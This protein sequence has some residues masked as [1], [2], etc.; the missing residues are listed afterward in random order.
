MRTIRELF[1]AAAERRTPRMVV[2]SGPAGVGKSRLGWEFRKY[3][4]GLV[5]VVNW[6]HGRC[7]S[8]GE[9]VSFWAL[10][11]MMRQR[12]GI[13]EDDQPELAAIKLV[14]GMEQWVPD[15]GERA[16]VGTRLARLLGVPY[17]A[18]TGAELSRE[19]LFAGWRI[20]FERM[21]DDAAG[22]AH[23]RG[24]PARRPRPARL[25]RPPRRLVPR[26]AGLRAG[27]R[28]ARAR[29][30]PA[31]L[32]D[33]AQPGA[34]HPRPARRRVDAP[35]GR[36]PR[37]RHA[38]RGAGRDRGPGA[39]RSAVRR[40]D[41]PLA[42]RP[43]RR[44]ADRRRLPPGRRRRRARRPG[45]PARAAGRAARRPGARRA[46]AGGRRGGARHV[47][48]GR[49]A[50]RGL[51]ARGRGASA[52]GWPSCC[53]ARCS[54]SRPTRC[55][56]S[57]AATGSP[58]TCCARSPTTRCRGGTARPATSPWPRTCARRSPN[59]GEEVVDVVARHYLDA[60]AA[61]PDDPDADAL[62]EQAVAALVRAAE[63]AARTGAPDRASR[64]YSQAAE[65]LEEAGGDPRR[66]AHLFERAITA[67]Y[68]SG[69]ANEVVDLAE[70]N[71]E[72]YTALGE[73]RAAAR[74]RTQLGRGLMRLGRYTDGPGDA[75]R[76]DRRSAG[77]AGRRHGHR[78]GA[79]R[80]ARDLRRDPRG[81]RRHRRGPAPG[82]GSGDSG[83]QRWP[84]CCTSAACTWPATT[85]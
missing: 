82:P 25:P 53:G 19:E 67:A 68:D 3:V 22:R 72:R 79:A 1:H 11:E 41:G 24:R 6:H 43:R 49:R 59:D 31:R 15:E 65:L 14:Q 54:R 58:R 70:A 46:A 16:Y 26:P 7:L 37:P 29:R 66:C 33:R 28:P 18:D 34:A 44:P 10:A 4:D 9:G 57:A 73:T 51:G 62:R 80:H 13:A 75:R 55:R 2:L 74:S 21:A 84:A 78:P 76:G 81:R 27:P 40:R 42:G 83:R 52:T 77:P 38:G 50:G 20:F 39:G 47:V 45:Q 56:R 23:A 71:I 17:A 61:V 85:G 32:R 69:A 64:S 63:R 60:L 48:P 12:L 35:A 5:D 36:R 30:R 8:Y